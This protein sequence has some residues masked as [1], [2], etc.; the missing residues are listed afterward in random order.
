MT[1]PAEFLEAPKLSRKLP[2]VLSIAEVEQFLSAFDVSTAE[3]TRNK[4][5][6]ETLYSCGL[7]ISELSG[8]LISNYYA[9]AG[10]VRIIGKGQ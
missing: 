5:I 3:G 8:L 2:E 4:A 10:F 6:C 7:R 9:D 1:S